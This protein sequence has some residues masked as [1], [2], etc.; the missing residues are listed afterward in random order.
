MDNWQAVVIAIAAGL[1]LVVTAFFSGLKEI[2]QTWMSRLNRKLKK[3]TYI[4]RVEKLAEYMD[5]FYSL[6]KLGSVQRCLI[7]HGHNCGGLPTPGKPYTVRAVFGWS[8]EPGKD[9]PLKKYDFELQVDD[10]YVRMLADL[11]KNGSIECVT[12]AMVDGSKLRTLY[13]MEGVKY[14][15]LYYLGLIDNEL[16]FL[17]AG[18]YSLIEFEHRIETELDFAID[19]MRTLMGEDE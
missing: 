17:S 12:D 7:F 8:T 10:H 6:K 14:T 18:S 15:K 13:E 1:A 2:V 3:Q 11:I 5:I 4:Q 16:I 19:R 9:D